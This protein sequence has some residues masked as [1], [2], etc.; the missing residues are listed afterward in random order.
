MCLGRRGRLGAAAAAPG[1]G[2]NLIIRVTGSDVTSRRGHVARSSRHLKPLVS[3][4]NAPGVLYH[5]LA[6][7]HPRS[8]ILQCYI[9]YYYKQTGS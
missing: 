2:G 1:P 8:L 7:E 6:V 5:T 3:S 4:Y 9:T